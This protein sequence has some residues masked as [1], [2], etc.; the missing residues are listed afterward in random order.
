MPDPY[1]DGEGEVMRAEHISPRKTGDN[2]QAK[3]IA[4][5]GYDYSLSEW[6]RIAVVESTD[7]P[8]IWGMVV[9]N[10]DGSS[11]GTGGS[12]T[13]TTDVLLLETG[14]RLLLEIGDGILL[15]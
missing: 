8:G 7:F 15:G 12:T 9:L 14:D 5:Y 10:P 13:P 3:R 1:T 11:I 2:I 4:T 6:R